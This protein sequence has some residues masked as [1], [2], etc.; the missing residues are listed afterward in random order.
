MKMATLEARITLF[1]DPDRDTI[2][3]LLRV[4]NKEIAASASIDEA[5]Q[6]PDHLMSNLIRAG[7]EDLGYTVNLV[8]VNS[9]TRV[10]DPATMRFLLDA[11]VYTGAM[12]Y[13][14]DLERFDELIRHVRGLAW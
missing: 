6:D 12:I 13:D 2:G 4:L 7:L 10:L 5:I 14:P 3:M 1:L 8:L 11:R 9:N